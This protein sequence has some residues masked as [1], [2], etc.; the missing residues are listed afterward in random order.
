LPKTKGRVRNGSAFIFS[1]QNTI[2]NS[3]PPLP[4]GVVKHTPQGKPSPINGEGMWGMI[5]PIE[6]EENRE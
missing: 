2:F 6:G 4:C 1:H 5:S 3:P